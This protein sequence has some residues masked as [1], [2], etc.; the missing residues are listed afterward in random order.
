MLDLER[1]LSQIHVHE[2]EVQKVYKYDR[3]LFQENL[4]LADTRKAE[5]DVAALDAA[6]SRHENVRKEAEAELQLYYREVEKQERIKREE[7]EKK[8]ERERHARAQA[9]AKRKAREEA[10]RIAAK[11]REQAAKKRA[12]EAEAKAEES[13]RVRREE[14][15]AR[16]KA[17]AEN[18]QKELDEKVRAKEVAEEE[19]ARKTLAQQTATSLESRSPQGL[20]A[21]TANLSDETRHQRYLQIHQN[22][23]SFRKEFW[24]QCK[25]DS[26]L[27]SKV[28]DMRRA[29]KTSVGQLTEAKGANKVPVGTPALEHF[30]PIPTNRVC[31]P[32]VS[33]RR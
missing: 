8:R 16:E 4:D 32:N 1:A 22:L 7:E 15:L 3:R 24:T 11:E 26:N 27:K 30:P 18:K 33:S 17:A 10:E 25:R 12:L 29:I 23:K 21:A 19:T 13:E 6:T 2:L 5:E 20:S 14:A 9:E 28:G 31:R